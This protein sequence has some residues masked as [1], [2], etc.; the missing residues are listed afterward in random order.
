MRSILG[1]H[2]RKTN[3]PVLHHENRSEVSYPEVRYW[4]SP[5][6]SLPQAVEIPTFTFIIYICY[7]VTQEETEEPD[8]GFKYVG[9]HKNQGG[10][11]N[12]ESN[13]PVLHHENRS[14]VSYP[15]VRY[16]HSPPLSFPQAV[17]IPTFTLI[18]YICYAVT[19]EE[20]EEPV[21]GPN[22]LGDTKNKVVKYEDVRGY[23][24]NAI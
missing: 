14:E 10:K 11:V 6:R 19:V 17:E 2:S 12:R 21:V 1:P 16:W 3:R 24:E 5:P 4:Y 7:A 18:I 22:T 13:R 23:I 9:I 8:G 15:E 20:T